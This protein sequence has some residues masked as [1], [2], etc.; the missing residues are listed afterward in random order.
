MKPL[1]SVII[2]VYK[3]EAYLDEC[4]E[5]LVAQAF[6]D[7]EIIL[8][9]DGSP[10]R[11]PAMCDAWAQKDSRISV[12]HKENG[13]VSSARNVAIEQAQGEWIWFVDSDD[14]VAPGAL[15]QLALRTKKQPDI[16]VFNKDISEEYQKD[17]RF[18]DDYYF[19]YRFGFEAWNKLYKTSIIRTHQIAFDTQETIGEDLL[20][21]ITYYQFA[22]RYLFSDLTLYHYREREDSAMGVS[23]PERLQKQLRLFSKIHALYQGQV[24]ERIL[25]Q[26]FI[27]HLVSGINQADQTGL[28]QKQLKTTI[29]EAYQTYA[30]DKGVFREALRC[31][32]RSEGASRLGSIRLQLLFF[33][34]QLI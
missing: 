3:V 8:V 30:F 14:T 19:Q 4:L 10:D 11:C 24:E 18:F 21:N 7:F 16:I 9:D 28:G 12:I 31:F 27:M 2:P 26:L 23:D 32:L 15:E 29:Q 33:R 17:G 34:W 6:Q 5:S 22:E 20:F 13:G 25:A 1:I